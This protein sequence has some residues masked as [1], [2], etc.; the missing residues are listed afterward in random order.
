MASSLEV[1]APVWVAQPA[2]SS[3]AFVGGVVKSVDGSDGSCVVKGVGGTERTLQRGSLMRANPVRRLTRANSAAASWRLPPLC[4][5][6]KWDSA[7]STTPRLSP[8]SLLC[9]AH[10]PTPQLT[11]PLPPR[12]LALSLSPAR[13]NLQPANHRPGWWLPTMRFSSTSTRPLSSPTCE[14]AS[15]ATPSTRTRARSSSP[16]TRSSAYRSTARTR[17]Q[18]TSS[19]SWVPWSPTSTPCPRSH[20]PRSCGRVAASRWWFPASPAPGRQRRT[21]S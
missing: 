10:P 1:G 17:C 15:V 16:S 5:P 14:R 13:T 4:R 19:R 3:E 12:S 6:A 11:L 7:P 18:P 20:T 21:S 8:D 2:D 9:T